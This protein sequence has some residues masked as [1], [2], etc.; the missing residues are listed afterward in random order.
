[1]TFLENI[2]EEIRN[3]VLECEKSSE[4][5][6]EYHIGFEDLGNHI[7][8][9]SCGKEWII[10]YHVAI[11]SEKEGITMLDFTMFIRSL[12]DEKNQEKIQKEKMKYVERKETEEKIEKQT[13]KMCHAIRSLEI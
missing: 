11:Q 5:K 13:K 2:I 7:R 12:S 1:M 6:F 9:C 4:I 10:P 3:H 8:C